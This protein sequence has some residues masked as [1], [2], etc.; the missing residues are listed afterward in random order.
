MDSG[1]AFARAE[2]RSRE[3]GITMQKSFFDLR[4]ASGWTV[5]GPGF[6]AG[7]A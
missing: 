3:A 2:F 6:G 4:S 1:I 5:I 7:S